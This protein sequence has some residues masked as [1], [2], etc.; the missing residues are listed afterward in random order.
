MNRR[1]YRIRGI[2]KHPTST[3][4]RG[5]LFEKKIKDQKALTHIVHPDFTWIVLGRIVFVAPT[6]C[7]S[8]YHADQQADQDVC[9]FHD[10][11]ISTGNELLQED[12]ANSLNSWNITPKYPVLTSFPHPQP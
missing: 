6:Q 3:K 7:K 2:K 1:R 12:K 9:F 4:K 11:W 5:V 10:K 8:Q